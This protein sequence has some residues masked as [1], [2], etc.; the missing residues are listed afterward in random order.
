MPASRLTPGAEPFFLA[1]GPAGCLLIHGFTGTPFEMR[2]LG[3]AVAAA[4]Y[5]VLAPRL[6][7]HGTRPADMN[8]AHWQDW[9]LSALDGYHLLAGIC[10]QVAAIGL[11]MGGATA[12]MLAANEPLA[13]VVSLGTPILLASVDRRLRFARAIGRFRRYQPKPADESGLELPSYSV[14]PV[15]ALAELLDYLKAVDEALPRVSAPA[16]LLHARA[17]QTVPA[18]NLEYIAGR[19]GSADKEVGWLEAGDHVITMD[20]GRE[21]ASERI[22]AFLAGRLPAG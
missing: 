10:P 8:R 19:V 22:L 1:G 20:A 7:G 3:E 17:D 12:L 18:H 21:A 2:D 15:P 11:S 16:L 5:T 13:A 6:F 9:Y 14:W 4:G